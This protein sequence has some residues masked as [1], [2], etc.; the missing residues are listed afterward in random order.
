[1]SISQ[2]SKRVPGRLILNLFRRL[3]PAEQ[4]RYLESLKTCAKLEEYRKS[5]LVIRGSDIRPTSGKRTSRI[6]SLG[7]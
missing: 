1:M 6:Y 2:L 4:E 5:G 3:A 7:R